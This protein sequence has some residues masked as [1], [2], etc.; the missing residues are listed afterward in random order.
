MFEGISQVGYMQYT[1]FMVN[2]GEHIVYVLF[3]EEQFKL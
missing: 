3:F 1:G 2:G